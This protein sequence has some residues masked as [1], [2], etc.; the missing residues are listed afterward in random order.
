MNCLSEVIDLDDDEHYLNIKIGVSSF[1][2][3]SLMAEILLNNAL[4]ASYG[5]ALVNYFEKSDHIGL[6]KRHAIQQEIHYGIDNDRFYV[7]YQPIVNTETGSVCSFEALV[8]LKDRSENNV[9]PSD[10]I[11]IAEES[12]DVIRIGDM[13]LESVCESLQHWY[14]KYPDLVKPVAVNLSHRQLVLTDLPVYIEEKLNRYK[15]PASLLQLEV[16]ESGLLSNLEK[17]IENITAIAN[18]GV[19][20]SLDDFGTG[21][22]SLSYLQRLDVV[23]LKL[24]KSFIDDICKNRSDYVLVRAIISLSHELEKEVVAEGVEDAGQLTLLKKHGCDY[25][26]GFYFSRPGGF[27][28]VDALLRSGL[29][30]SS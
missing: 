26:Q 21:Y 30:I 10:F 22:S 28:K 2:Q 7:E 15:I 3:H 23:K 1:P 16:T 9:S 12:E 4:N 13:V 6:S 11:Q 24:D 8:R 27:H 5:V 25:I 14:Q 29:T 20:F 17:A 19:N 18:L